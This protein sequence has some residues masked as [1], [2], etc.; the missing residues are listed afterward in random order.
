MFVRTLY[1]TGLLKFARIFW[2]Y[3]V[4]EHRTRGGIAKGDAAS[5]DPSLALNG[6]S[7]QAVVLVAELFSAIARGT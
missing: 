7:H 4:V 6:T 1:E 3:V 5:L 2:E